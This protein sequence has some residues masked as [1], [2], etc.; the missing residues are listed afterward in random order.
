MIKI[1]V[2]EDDLEIQSS[3][4]TFLSETGYSILQACDGM[5]AMTLFDQS[6]QLVLLDLMLPKVD[7]FAVC[8]WIRKK[9]N[10]P[11]IMLTALSDE[12]DQVRGFD[13]LIDDYIPKP[14]SVS[15]LLRKIE[16]ILRRT[17]KEDF[18]DFIEYKD[19]RI[20]LVGMNVFIKGK[21]IKLTAKEFQIVLELFS[22]QGI[23]LTRDV[24]LTKL[25]GYDAFYD[26]R[27]INTNM[28]NIRKKLSVDYI[29]TIRGVGY[30]VEKLS[31]K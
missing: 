27:V 29:Q 26:D 1:L 18:S 30:K 2:V 23:V 10:V 3:L 4:K 16:A 6:F 13:L 22:H 19:L 25:W 5:E 24:L 17:V 21:I 12:E 28:R 9:S 14:F 20:D 11:I 31:K 15:I 7:G 8:E